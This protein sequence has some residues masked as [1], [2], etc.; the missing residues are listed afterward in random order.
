MLPR[1]TRPS[2]RR[3]R[4]SV[5]RRTLVAIEPGKLSAQA[6]Q[7]GQVID[8]D[9]GIVGVASCVVLMVSLGDTEPSERPALSDDRFGIPVRGGQPI[10]QRARGGLLGSVAVLDPRAVPRPRIR[11]LVVPRG[12]V[13]SDAEEPLEQLAVAPLLRVVDAPDRL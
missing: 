12:W 3:D 4:R 2:A 11:T 6:F 1:H 8:D 5:R 7:L 10:D 13:V 9:V